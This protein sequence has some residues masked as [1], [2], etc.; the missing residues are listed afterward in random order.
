MFHLMAVHGVDAGDVSYETDR[1]QFIGRGRTV[2]SPRAMTEA[3][4]L[5]GSE[6]SVLDP[7]VAIR[8]R[9]TLDPEQTATI[10]I[11][12]CE[13]SSSEAAL[14]QALAPTGL[15]AEGGAAVAPAP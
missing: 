2:A 12:Y 11:G 14:R 6:G 1:M 15:V 3:G 4:R 13:S 5:S 10:D 9:V 8:H 7:I